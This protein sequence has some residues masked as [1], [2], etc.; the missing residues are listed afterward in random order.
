MG[1][2]CIID[3][4]KT[5]ATYGLIYKN[6]LHCKLH[7]LLNEK[8]VKNIQ[9]NIINCENRARFGIT[10]IIRCNIHKEHN[11]INLC[12]KKCQFK[13]CK[14]TA[15]LGDPGTKMP[16][17]CSNHKNINSINTTKILCEYKNCNIIASFGTEKA[18]RCCIHKNTN[19]INLLS[20]KCII[21]N[22]KKVACYGTLVV[23]KCKTHKNK[24]DINLLSKKCE[25]LGCNIY[26]SFGIKIALRCK[27]HKLITDINLKLKR[28]IKCSKTATFGITTAQHCNEHKLLNEKNLRKTIFACISCGL[29]YNTIR[30]RKQTLC[31]Y[32]D[33]TKIL[34]KKELIIKNLLEKNNYT[35]IYDKPCNI[36][37][38]CKKY[39]PDFLIDCNT[40]FIIVE[41]DEFAHKNYDQSCE[42]IRM[43]IICDNLGLPTIF[44]RYNPDNKN[45]STKI[46]HAKLLDVLNYNLKNTPDGPKIEYLY[47]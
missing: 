4:C 14:K 9:C 28:C 40:Y 25:S 20:K 29:N 44:I 13:N 31:Y 7:K 18:L 12:S 8:N 27:K 10:K 38:E 42:I 16:K 26:P 37:N 34:K 35:F 41:V 22:C 45:F 11:M 5:Y 21:N 32:C 3:N 43:N 33:P 47:Y 6:P 30:K 17:W 46:K 23:E 2:Y 15:S 19:D 36:N 1:K 39:R 24:N